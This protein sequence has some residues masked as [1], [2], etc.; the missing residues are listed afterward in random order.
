MPDAE[1]CYHDFKLSILSLRSPPFPSKMAVLFKCYLN[2]YHHYSNMGLIFWGKKRKKARKR[3]KRTARSKREPVRLDKSQ[4]RDDEIFLKLDA[5]VTFLRKHDMDVKDSISRLASAK[6]VVMEANL[7]KIIKDKLSQGMGSNEIV[8]E[9][10]SQ[11][12]CSRST[13][14]RYLSQHKEMVGVSVKSH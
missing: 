3:P 11:G 1:N 13:A 10:V 9:L 8:Q 5:I 6:R 12:A 7:D 2:D 14:Y 4:R